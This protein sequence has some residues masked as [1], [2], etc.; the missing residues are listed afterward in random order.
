MYPTRCEHEIILLGAN[1][2]TATIVAE[3]ITKNLPTNLR[4]AVAGR[5]RQKLEALVERLKA[6]NSDRRA[7]GRLSLVILYLQRPDT[8]LEVVGLEQTQLDALA[9]CCRL[10]VNGIGPYHL[11]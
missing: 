1:G 9:K 4:W 8:L 11:H 6:M 2:Y 10:I 7:P 3:Y 5:L